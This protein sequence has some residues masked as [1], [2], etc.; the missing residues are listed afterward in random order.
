M[1]GPPFESEHRGVGAGVD[2]DDPGRLPVDL[3]GAQVVLD[4]VRGS[5]HQAVRDD[6]AHPE[7]GGRSVAGGGRDRHGRDPI[8]CPAR[9]RR[10]GDA[11]RG[12]DHGVRLHSRM[13]TQRATTE[14]C[15]Q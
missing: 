6:G 8:R 2:E 13:L 11:E 14:R 12:G 1:P 7:P 4:D 9:A 15:P 3:H 10:Q 5:Q